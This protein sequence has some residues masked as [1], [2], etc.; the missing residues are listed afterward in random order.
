M[1]V[2]LVE[3]NVQALKFADKAYILE[4]GEKK[5]EGTAQELMANEE[6]GKLYL[7]R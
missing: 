7:G 1:T 4:G 5:A 3:Q 6:I 2:L